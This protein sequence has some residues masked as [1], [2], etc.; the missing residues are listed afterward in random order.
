MNKKQKCKYVFVILTYRNT[1]DIR[2]CIQSILNNV[3]DFK[4]IVVDSFY[5]KETKNEIEEIASQ[6]NS[7]FITIPNKG[8]SFGNNRGIE[9]AMNSFDFDYVVV[10]NPDTIITH[11]DDSKL[12]V[13]SNYVIGPRIVN[14]QNKY[15]NPLKFKRSKILETMIYKGLKFHNFFLLY[16]GFAINKIIRIAYLCVHLFRDN[17]QVYALHGSCVIFPKSVLIKIGLPYDENIFLFAEEDVL[18]Q[19]C[20]KKGIESYVFDGISILHK[21]DGSM[22]FNSS[23]VNHSNL[24][25]SYIYMF[26]KYVQGLD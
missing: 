24:A 19:K 11:F 5:D 9:Y 1:T 3:D 4:I 23:S 12:D 14:L 17:I 2:D 25:K 16:L 6:Y 20:K 18:A 10:L 13:Y 22:N 21:E 7:I 26:E 8:Y 15:Q